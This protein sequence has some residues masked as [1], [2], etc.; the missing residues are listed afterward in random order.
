MKRTLQASLRNLNSFSVEALAG[1]LIELESEDDL[2]ELAGSL[3]F[4]PARDL[5]L[6]GGSNVV[7]AGD[8]QALVLR[9]IPVIRL[10]TSF[11][12][13]PNLFRVQTLLPTIGRQ[14]R[15]VHRRSLDHGSKLVRGI[16]TPWRTVSIGHETTLRPGRMAAT[17]KVM[18][19]NPAELWQSLIC[20]ARPT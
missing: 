4:D 16:P 14:F 17:G 6:G 11:P 7:I 2:Q 10:F 15:L 12:P 18:P 5:V 20:L 19:I 13:L 1:Q 9:S 8:L 3:E